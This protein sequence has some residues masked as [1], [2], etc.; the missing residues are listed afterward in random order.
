VNVAYVGLA[1]SH[2]YAYRQIL[3]RT[4]HRSVAVWDRDAAA[5]A[6][7]AKLSGARPT[8]TI[9][10]IPLAEIDGA[11]LT[12]RLPERIDHALYFL[13]R[14][15]PI[16]IGKPMAVTTVDLDRLTAAVRRTGTPLLATSVLRFA[17]VLTV[18]RRHLEAGT[19]GQIVAVRAVSAHKIDRYMEEPHVWQDEPEQ[20]GG[21]LI[22][23]GVHAL[24]MLAVV[25][26]TNFRDVT[27]RTDR[28]FHTGSRSEDVAFL[29]IAWDSG[30]LA[31]AEVIG[32]V[33]VEYYAIE[34]YGS[35]RV[36]HIAIPSGQVTDYRGTALGEPD[37]W[38]EFGYTGTM[39]A[40]VEMCQTRRMPVPLEESEA[41][42]Q[43]LIAARRAAVSGQLQRVGASDA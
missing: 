33:N 8:A 25:L 28:R 38:V 39:A 17:P 41:I 29:Q 42:T 31:S 30:L 10:E 5:R 40:F 23:M 2:P 6:E 11:I 16:Y 3:E 35:E 37:L 4:G 14:G 15:I 1:H 24:E 36:I 18:L 7:F 26:G 20:G 19:V 13:D 27:C 9:E 22:G 21:T 43:T 32:G 34:V 12:G